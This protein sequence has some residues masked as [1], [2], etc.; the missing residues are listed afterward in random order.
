MRGEYFMKEKIAFTKNMLD[1]F[2]RNNWNY[3]L[4][5]EEH[6]LRTDN[7]VSLCDD[8]YCTYSLEYYN[9]YQ[10]ACAEIENVMK[11][12]CAYFSEEE[13]DLEKINE[14]NFYELFETICKMNLI[15]ADE[16]TMRPVKLMDYQCESKYPI[17]T[18][19]PW[20]DLKENEKD[21]SKYI[22]WWQQHN[23]VKHQRTNFLSDIGN[24]F[25]YANLR[26]TLYSLG[27]LYIL[28]LCFIYK[29]C[30]DLEIEY[31]DY[32]EG[33]RSILFQKPNSLNIFNFG[34]EK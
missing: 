3:Y 9:I 30:K 19:R 24:T 10:S 33:Q 7:Y 29:K 6:L 21:G 5:L 22:V 12:V 16:K 32:L 23:K 31:N 13:V 18:F 28:N 8:N 17:S 26:N 15:I 34:E 11:I 20:A 14:M 25:S 1:I 27:A 2:K 4:L